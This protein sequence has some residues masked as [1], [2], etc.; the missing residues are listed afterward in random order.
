M[1]FY[2]KNMYPYFI[3]HLSMNFNSIG[4]VFEIIK[5]WYAI[6]YALYYV[7]VYNNNIIN[8]LIYMK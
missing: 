2:S 4:F 5:K 6:N 7:H 1:Y 8:N 3:G